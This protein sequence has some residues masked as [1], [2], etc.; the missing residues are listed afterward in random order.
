MAGDW[1]LSSKDA[2]IEPRGGHT[3]LKALC[4][5][6]RGQWV[7]SAQGLTWQ[8]RGFTK[9]AH[10]IRFGFEGAGDDQPVLRATVYGNSQANINT[11][12]HIRNINGHLEFDLAPL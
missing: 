12:E 8:K 1:Q 9:N 3:I 11:R 10:D 6:E 7:H 4:R 5:N 2:Y